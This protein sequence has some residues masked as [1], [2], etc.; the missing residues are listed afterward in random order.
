MITIVLHSVGAGMLGKVSL[1]DVF[2]ENLM[3]VTSRYP[4]MGC[5]QIVEKQLGGR[6]R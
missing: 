3:E 6:A 2:L 5:A 4:V 1:F